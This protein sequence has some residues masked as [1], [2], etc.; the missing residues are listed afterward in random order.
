M[1][2]PP[3]SVI[4]PAYNGERYLGAAI[5][6]VLAQE[7]APGE[8]IV[9][10]DGS[11]DGSAMIAERYGPPV[12]V[13]RQPR[14]GNAVARN[15]GLEVARGDNIA[16]LD[17]DDLWTADSL[18][19]RLALLEAEP[20][21]D[22]VWGRVEFFVSP[23]TE[24]EAARSLV[25]P[26][27]PQPGVLAGAMLIR[28]RVYDR[29]GRFE[30]ELRTGQFVSWILRCRDAGIRELGMPE[31][32]MRRRLHASNYTRTHRQE[33]AEYTRIVHAALQRRRQMGGPT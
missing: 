5:D 27:G 13:V 25:C 14:G 31:V 8:V 20:E 15:R 24:P 28:R 1:S 4:I 6:S 9:V 11:T 17:A 10:D 3:V 32:V 29:V 26:A 2:G 33:L 23:D 30:P 16:W 12:V 19:R 21:I 18:G 22:I 7:P